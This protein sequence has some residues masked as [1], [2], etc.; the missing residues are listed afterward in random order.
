MV[1]GKIP[2]EL[3]I[4]LRSPLIEFLILPSLLLSACASDPTYSPTSSAVS[5]GNTTP[6]GLQNQAAA[7]LIG[8]HVTFRGADYYSL[9]NPQPSTH[10]AGDANTYYDPLELSSGTPLVLASNLLDETTTI[11][12]SFIKNVSVD[13]TDSNLFI[14][15]NKA[16]SC[17]YGRSTLAPIPSNCAAFDNVNDTF[18]SIA[19]TTD[20]RLLVGGAPSQNPYSIPS[21]N[22]IVRANAL[23]EPYSVILP[24]A[25]YNLD[26]VVFIEK[27]DSSTNAV[28]IKT[29][30]S[31]TVGDLI[32]GA[33]ALTL[34]NGYLGFIAT[35]NED[36]VPPYY[37][38]PRTFT[39]TSLTSVS[40]PYAVPNLSYDRQLNVDTT[41]GNVAIT[42][43]AASL[44]PGYFLLIRKTDTSINT[45]T[46]TPNAPDN[47]EDPFGT[48]FTS[49]SLTT[50]EPEIVLLSVSYSNGTDPA[51]YY[52]TTQNPPPVTGTEVGTVAVEYA[53]NTGSTTVLG[54][55]IILVDALNSHL[56]LTLPAANASQNKTIMIQRIDS[57]DNTVTLTTLDSTPDVTDITLALPVVTLISTSI[58]GEPGSYFWKAITGIPYRASGG[59]NSGYYTTTNSACINSG[60]IVSNDPLVN[61]TLVGGV[62]FDIDRTQLGP[63]ENLLLNITFFP[64]GSAN[65]PLNQTTAFSVLD[66]PIIKVHLAKIGQSGDT[67]RSITQPRILTYGSTTQYV[68]TA[69]DFAIL[70]SPAGQIQQQQLYLPIAI[71]PGIDRI[72]VQRYSG[73]IIFIDATLFKTGYR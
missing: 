18:V 11:R 54:N 6:V 7:A 71:D 39:S 69:Q 58:T 19:T 63:H 20:H 24:P 59:Y 16:F 64:L 2:M 41:N 57:S 61:S 26:K 38:A 43:P 23:F 46:L 15:P 9:F 10:C 3:R 68:Q 51:T 5:T 30:G 52:W 32:T 72:H 12:P 73:N 25:E 21:G 28:T 60:P 49:Y 29:S 65:F 48:Q 4:F 44:S 66:T 67:I 14:P 13:I 62:Y 45:V 1:Y 22:E 35:E 55:Q 31:D 8:G 42:L 33:A 56:S 53:I 17:S 34:Q 70:G 47:I 27:V 37:W 50:R 40:S 36:A